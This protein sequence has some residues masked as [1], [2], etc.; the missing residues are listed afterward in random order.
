[1]SY[2]IALVEESI[3]VSLELLSW[4]EQAGMIFG[5]LERADDYMELTT[6]D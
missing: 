3:T 4:W 2:D 1:M 6:V 5:D